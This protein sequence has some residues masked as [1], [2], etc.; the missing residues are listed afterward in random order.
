MIF[1]VES[2]NNATLMRIT[3]KDGKVDY[4]VKMSDGVYEAMKR[5]DTAVLF[6]N[7]TMQ[8]NEK[9]VKDI[10]LKSVVQCRGAG[11]VPLATDGDVIVPDESQVWPLRRK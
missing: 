10:T 3:T 6:F 11:W 2:G 8:T 5:Y 9:G 1:R 4:A 7:G